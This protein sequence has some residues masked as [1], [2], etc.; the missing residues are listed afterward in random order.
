[1][2][3]ICMIGDSH[4]AALKLAWSTLSAEFPDLTL[5]FFAAP[6]KTMDGLSVADG[7]L[8]PGSHPLAGSLKLTSGGKTSIDG[9]YDR[10]V[11]HGLELGIAFA[12][13]ISRKYRA[14]RHATDWRTPISD[15]CFAEAVCGA[16]R[17]TVAG[18]TL[19]K[20][21]EI[22]KAPILVLPAPMADAK[23]Q[24]VRQ[25]LVEAGEARDVVRLFGAGCERLAA[26]AG[27]RFLPQPESTLD[28]D[29]IGTKASFSSSPARFH[30]ELARADNSHMNTAYGEAVLRHALAAAVS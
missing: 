24:K 5:D 7:Q 23:N 18:R 10:Y 15:D 6:G 1:M 30:A 11:I 17:A 19:A 27:A 12:L 22:T 29:G 26:S 20:L 14:E 2:S 9:L 3:R 4:L 16:A 8:V 25:T 21:R 13:E 28:A